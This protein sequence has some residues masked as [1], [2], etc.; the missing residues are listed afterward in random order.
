MTD[1]LTTFVLAGASGDLAKKKIYPVLWC[2]AHCPPRGRH[3]EPPSKIVV[4]A[5][6]QGSAKVVHTDY[7]KERA[8]AS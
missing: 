4:P 1:S 7:V 8:C 6:R 3:R 2:V 5:G